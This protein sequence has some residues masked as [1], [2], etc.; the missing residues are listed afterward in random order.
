MRIPG[1]E[2]R[3]RQR[4]QPEVLRR[5]VIG[6]DLHQSQRGAGDNAGTRQRQRHPPKHQR[7]PHPQRSRRFKRACRL[8]R[9][10]G[11]PGQVH[12]R[13]KTHRIDEGRAPEAFDGD[14][15]GA[16]PSHAGI[17]VSENVARR[18][19]R[20]DQQP[21]EHA[22]PGKVAEAHQPGARCAQHDRAAAADQHQRQRSH[23]AVANEGGAELDGRAAGQSQH[24][25]RERGRRTHDGG[26]RR[27]KLDAVEVSGGRA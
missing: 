26:E 24:H 4:R 22:P 20:N 6:G 23:R 27:R 14:G 12:V 7:W 2:D 13:I 5:A 21:F 1:A 3:G 16:G 25:H 9:K 8:A 19:Q 15:G 11:A 18:R 17:G 10:R